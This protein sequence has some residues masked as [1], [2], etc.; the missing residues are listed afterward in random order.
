MPK[1]TKTDVWG[2]RQVGYLRQMM[3][4]KK[5]QSKAGLVTLPL[6]DDR[7]TRV[8]VAFYPSSGETKWH[9]L[10]KPP[11]NH[12]EIIGN[13]FRHFICHVGLFSIVNIVKRIAEK[14]GK[15]ILLHFGIITFRFYYGITR[16]PRMSWFL[17]F[18]IPGNPYLWIWIYQITANSLRKSKIIFESYFLENWNLESAA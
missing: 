18:W 13:L 4:W 2:R 9:F 8:R 5:F 7:D 6:A 15:V 3:E 14:L 11:E 17:G 1:S 10:R 16:K 12:R